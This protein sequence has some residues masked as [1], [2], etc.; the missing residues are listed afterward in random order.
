MAALICFS[1]AF[2]IFIATLLGSTYAIFA[3]LISTIIFIL[4]I[5][6][7][8][9]IPL[10][11]IVLGVVSLAL[12]VFCATD[13]L[14]VKP[15][16]NLEGQELYTKGQVVD[17]DTNGQYYSY[18]IK[19]TSISDDNGEVDTD[20]FK[21][22]LT[23]YYNLDTEIGNTVSFSAIYSIPEDYL[24]FSLKAYY[25]AKGIHICSSSS[26]SVIVSESS[27]MPL[28]YYFQKINDFFNDILYEKLP[29]QT[30]QMTSAMLLG[31][32]DQ[33]DDDL[34]E[35][36]KIAG[37]SH[38]LVISGTHV[39]ILVA[40]ISSFMFFTPE[41]SKSRNFLLIFIVIIF[42]GVVGFKYSIIRSGIMA[43]ISLLTKIIGRVYSNLHSLALAIGIICLLNPFACGDTGLIL[44]FFA[45]LGIV[46][47]TDKIRLFLDDHFNSPYYI[48]TFVS[49]SLSVCVFMIP[50]SM[51]LFEAYS[52]ASFFTTLVLIIPLTVIIYVGILVCFFGPFIYPLLVPLI[53]LSNLMVSFS[54]FYVRH[55]PS[56]AYADMNNNWGIIFIGFAVMIIL[57]Y[58]F[59]MK[60]GCVIACCSSIFFVGLGLNLHKGSDINMTLSYESNEYQLTLEQ[61]EETITITSDSFETGTDT[62]TVV[63]ETT[64]ET[65]NEVIYIEGNG[66]KFLL[67]KDATLISDTNTNVFIG[68]ENDENVSSSIKILTEVSQTD[69]LPNGNYILLEDTLY[70]VIDKNGKI[71]LKN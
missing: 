33:L 52:L 8:K 39:A 67:E 15:I 53:I 54:I 4:S 17:I 50:I 20:D 18:T 49:A 22:L 29:Y 32:S 68:E 13:Y 36:F 46:L 9:K 37:G 35:Y 63:G 40:F 7:R 47:F 61:Y 34:V 66:T 31:N 16:E 58:R 12:F 65:K 60:K 56:W 64:V 25:S 28:N 57:A 1:Y 38:I 24:G 59:N 43:I 62:L 55:V 45:T 27:T 11:T 26:S 14:Y 5:F 42:M 70:I 30:A 44:S 21:T 19:V 41:V 6:F 23:T 71:F 3:T 69:S 2:G 48:S 51:W 10:I